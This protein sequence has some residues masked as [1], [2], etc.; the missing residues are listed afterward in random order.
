MPADPPLSPTP[1]IPTD[2]WQELGAR[3][4]IDPGNRPA[5][6]GGGNADRRPEDSR[7]VF[8]ARLPHGVPARL[9]IGRDL[10]STI[11]AA[12]GFAAA[13]PA[14]SPAPLWKTRLHDLDVL[15]EVFFEGVSLDAAIRS[16]SLASIHVHL[17]M[18][19]VAKDL[20]ATT[21]PSDDEARRQEWLTWQQEVAAL[22]IWSGDEQEMLAGI[23]FPLLETV[24]LA[25]PPETRWTHG[26]PTGTNILLNTGGQVRLIDTEFAASTH[27]FMEDQVRFHE[28]TEAVHLQPGLFSPIPTVLPPA[29]R[30]FT[31]L[32]QI[33]REVHRNHQSY[34]DRWL[35][36][37][38]GRL[39]RV[40]EEITGEPF[41]GCA[42][43]TLASEPHPAVETAQI[44]WSDDGEWNELKSRR[45]LYRRDR[46]QTLVFPL[47]SATGGFLRFDPASSTQ[48]VR[49]RKIQLYTENGAGVSGFGG[50]S[51]TSAVLRPEADTVLNESVEGPLVHSPT[52]DPRLELFL[53]GLQAGENQ[54]IEVE[55]SALETESDVEPPNP[56]A[57]YLEEARWMLGNSS[58][59]IRFAGWC[60]PRQGGAIRAVEARVGSRVLASVEPGPRPDVQ[61]YW[62]GDPQ[63]LLTGFVLELPH[64]APERLIT[65]VALTDR[66]EQL[67]F[68]DVVAG[69]LPDRGPL[70][71]NYPEWAQQHAVPVNSDAAPT[72]RFSILL[73]VF[74][75]T[76]EH[77]ES[78]LQSVVAQSHPHWE[79]CIVDDA[80]TRAKVKTLLVKA[81]DSDPRVRLQVRPAN[82][83]IA[84]AT[85]DAL[86]MAKGNFVLMLDHDDRLHPQ[87]LAEF[88][89][90]LSADPTSEAAYADEEKI[91]E[92]GRPVTPF[93]KPGFSP[94]FLRGV[95]YPGHPLAVKTSV[96]R[97]VGGFDP[98]YDGVQDYEFF[99][100]V[101]ERTQR[102]LH[103]PRILYQWR[104]SA[105]SSALHGNIKGN[106]DEKQVCAVR[107]HLAR[108]GD[109]RRATSL[110]GHRVRLSISATTLPSVSLIL[111]W[112]F[113]AGV[114]AEVWRQLVYEGG[115]PLHQLVLPAG[116]TELLPSPGINQRITPVS[117]P[118][119][120]VGGTR[121]AALAA[122][123][124]GEIIVLMT[125]P[126]RRLSKRWLAELT[127]LASRPDSGFVSGLLLSVKDRVL[128]SGWV[129][130]NQR[131]A[132][133][134]NEFDATGD[135]YN[136][137][138]RCNR[139]I[140][141]ASGLCLAFQ[142]NL[143]S[144][145]ATSTPATH[146]PWWALDCSLRA[147][148]EGY[149][150][151]VAA[152]C[153]IYTHLKNPF[154]PGNNTDAEAFFR[155]K[156]AGRLA[157]PDPFYN[158]QFDSY[159]ADYR[160]HPGSTSD[161]KA[162]L[163]HGLPRASFDGC[164][165]V[166]GWCLH[167]D[168]T[169]AAV[170]LVVP[171]QL[172]WSA[173][174]RIERPDVRAAFPEFGE[175]NAGFELRV[176]LP[177]GAHDTRLEAVLDNGNIHVLD[178]AVLKVSR[179]KRLHYSFAGSSQ[180]LLRFQLLAGPTHPPKPLRT[181]AFP[182]E[183]GRAARPRF[184]IVT[185]SYQQA[186]FLE[187]TM[188]SVLD[189][190]GVTIDYVVQD[191]GSTDGSKA[192]IKRLAALIREDRSPETGDRDQANNLGSMPD[193]PPSASRL[194][195][196]V[197]R[198]LAF[199][200]ESAPDGG[201]TDAICQ[202]F[203]KTSGEPD[204]LM[205]WINS[206][207]FYLPGTLA[208][209][210][211]HFARHPELDVV[212]GHRVLVD[213]HSRQ[214]GR[215]H[216]PAHDD[217]ILRL[218]DFVPQET[219]FWRRRIWEK[220]GG[221]DPAFQF[222]MDW[223]LLLRF[224]AAGARIECLP[225]ALACFRIHPDQKTSSQILTTGQREIDALRLRTFGRIIPP[226]EIENHP[227]MLAYL[228]KSA[229]LELMAELGGR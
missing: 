10:S 77:L 45:L 195:P 173:A 48:S 80:S 221:L 2:F 46:T 86:A 149:H 65:L 152:N 5:P 155:A 126:P 194:L 15:A 99:L 84:R 61:A 74:N 176:R 191:G 93:L 102:I 167:H 228:R 95:M 168:H 29:W 121:A 132:P 187:E 190:P 19:R 51:L 31:W 88:A 145:L 50:L 206:D 41:L 127:A 163:D 85:N 20:V 70:I 139:E 177:P 160:L 42:W 170:R 110:G 130:G 158:P 83:G 81:A 6:L 159:R 210:A 175:T 62:Q 109:P 204:D 162:Y 135:G 193:F 225:R 217:E 214:I 108:I 183:L 192:I 111:D 1:A 181:P 49:I 52:A 38:L 229:R 106:M 67:A 113:R 199:A 180:Q 58:H 123:A 208:F 34:L 12:E 202:G 118:A 156:W 94:E 154:T 151:R 124:E 68:H 47:G 144:M 56:V 150:N 101:V 226:A 203:A 72:I 223:D 87:A 131:L 146:S 11:A 198:G 120:A 207:D 216:L 122:A 213:E 212:Y 115:V 171:G 8:K 128:E 134:M 98:S 30:L 172:T 21:Q 219:L 161:F 55:L 143:Q 209:V 79:L 148:E 196:P 165:L 166:R 32:S 186:A 4:L 169:I 91:N 140:S 76:P 66:G 25:G 60:H 35:P 147:Q 129:A 7:G 185:P 63:A 14:L 182:A 218:N 184:S 73:P 39:R 64:V 18:A 112:D 205:A 27:F 53:P 59:A 137:S 107:E 9:T 215:W 33:R 28:F 164:L 82:G 200:W 142:R 3:G 13:C 44:F 227:I 224:Q 97:A 69:D 222:A 78:C 40:Y 43:P 136:G 174:C 117:L 89:H 104:Q 92:Q 197:C 100:R 23:L 26:D 17:A 141:A 90:A 22:P 157:R 116:A 36:L 179:F 201:Q 211:G 133:A 138:L 103:L 189:Q 57:H 188:R 178:R 16:Q 119:Q 220:V 37:R 71:L 24:V 96:A 125:T 153:R 105:G 54:L 114:N 75:P